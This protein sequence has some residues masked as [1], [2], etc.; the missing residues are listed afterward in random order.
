MTPPT[1]HPTLLDTLGLL[2]ARLED[3]IPHPCPRCEG[4]GSYEHPKWRDWWTRN[5]A[6]WKRRN[7]A[8]QFDP[9]GTAARFGS[10]PP[11]SAA[12]W[13]ADPPPAAP[14]D[15]LC[16]ECDGTGETRRQD[17]RAEDVLDLLA[18]VERL[19]PA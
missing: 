19:L 18:L 11:L 13:P 7:D 2:R 15:A 4:A 3:A 14:M 8:W 5:A 12:A 1:I 6:E 9:E 16:G 17:V 10:L